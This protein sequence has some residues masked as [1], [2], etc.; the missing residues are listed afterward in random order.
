MA[1]REAELEHWAEELDDGLPLCLEPPD[2]L[3]RHEELVR[4]CH[5]MSEERTKLEELLARQTALLERGQQLMTRHA[6][7]VTR[8]MI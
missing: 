8:R 7:Y 5:E 6:R 1:R 4:L 3:R 2:L